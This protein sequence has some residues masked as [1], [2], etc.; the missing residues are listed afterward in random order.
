MET[1]PHAE[2]VADAS[3]FQGAA[4]THNVNGSKKPVDGLS[5]E[6][7]ARGWD[8]AGLIGPKFPLL[9]GFALQ[10]DDWGWDFA[11]LVGEG[12]SLV[13]FQQSSLQTLVGSDSLGNQIPVWLTAQVKFVSLKLN[14]HSYY[15]I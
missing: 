6:D 15:T 12:I 13:T 5:M 14:L 1:S 2:E 11:A 7:V 3:L 9:S 4:Q 10:V 8:A